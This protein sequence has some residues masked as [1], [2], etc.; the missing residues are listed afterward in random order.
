[1]NV[2]LVSIS[3]CSREYKISLDG[4]LSSNVFMYF[5]GKED[6]NLAGLVI[7]KKKKKIQRM[8]PIIQ[9]IREELLEDRAQF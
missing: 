1:M 8:T 6:K 5:S 2:I 4:Y 3:V 9:T 7:I